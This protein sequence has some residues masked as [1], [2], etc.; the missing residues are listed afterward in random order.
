MSKRLVRAPSRAG[1]AHVPLA[2]VR[3]R[4]IETKGS[5]FQAPTREEKGNRDAAAR[6]VPEASGCLQRS[7]VGVT[8]QPG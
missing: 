4:A 6:D 7:T 3:L 1:H 8:H 2:Y 5:A